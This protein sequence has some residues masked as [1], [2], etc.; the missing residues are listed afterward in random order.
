MKIKML[1][2]YHRMTRLAVSIH[3]SFSLFPPIH[4]PLIPT[5]I[6]AVKDFAPALFCRAASTES[7]PLPL[8]ANGGAL[9]RG[10]KGGS[11][12]P[13]GGGMSCG[14]RREGEKPQE[15]VGRWRELRGDGREDGKLQVV[16]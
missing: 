9:L 14:S 16:G 7:K 5:L 4:R 1:T 13:W 12:E 8:L 3:S 10:R 2:K 15:G 11:C 6:L